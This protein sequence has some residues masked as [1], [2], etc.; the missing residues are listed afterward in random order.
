MNRRSFLQAAAL[1]TVAAVQSKGQVNPPLLPPPL[2]RRPLEVDLSD[3][4]AQSY[5]GDHLTDVYVRLEELNP[6][7]LGEL[8]GA[9]LTI[10]ENGAWLNVS[11][12]IGDTLQ[13]RTVAPEGFRTTHLLGFVQGDETA[14][15]LSFD[16]ARGGDSFAVTLQDADDPDYSAVRL[17]LFAN[18]G[19]SQLRL[20]LSTHCLGVLNG[21]LLARFFQCLR[22]RSAVTGGETL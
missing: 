11:A 1:S 9:R 4:G 8:S 6:C 17:I 18:E 15:L 3:P 13:P 12:R 19:K 16:P 21:D 2:A 5:L 7:D 14:P 22:R 20:Y 10:S